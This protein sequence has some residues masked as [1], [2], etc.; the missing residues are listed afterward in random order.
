MAGSQMKKGTI[1]KG[2]SPHSAVNKKGERFVKKLEKL[3]FTFGQSPIGKIVIASNESGLCAIMLGENSEFLMHCLK[4][5]FKHHQL[6]K[7]ITLNQ[8]AASIIGYIKD[9]IKKP[10]ISLDVQG[11]Q[12]QRDVWKIICEIPCGSTLSYQDVA[13]RLGMPKAARA[14]ARAC[15]CNL[16]A[17]LIPCHRVVSSSGALA[18]YRWGLGLKKRLLER[19]KRIVDLIKADV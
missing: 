8:I 4:T 13:K 15:A 9:P 19:E 6:I 5:A 3:R 10:A 16:L 7:D 18:G 17:L 2:K 12:F 11:S 14:V 1:T